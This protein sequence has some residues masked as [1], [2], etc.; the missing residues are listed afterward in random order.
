M[1]DSRHHIKGDTVGNSSNILIFK[2]HSLKDEI[3]VLFSKTAMIFHKKKTSPKHLKQSKKAS[4]SDAKRTS[5]VV[6]I[7]NNLKTN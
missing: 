6:N 7:P 1:I 2:D 3:K 4:D 5:I